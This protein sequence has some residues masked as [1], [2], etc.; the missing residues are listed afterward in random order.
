VNAFKGENG[1]KTFSPFFF[2]YSSFQRSTEFCI[3]LQQG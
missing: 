2:Y 3:F 1:G